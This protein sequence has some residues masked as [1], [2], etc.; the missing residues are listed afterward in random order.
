MLALGLL[1]AVGGPAWAAPTAQCGGQVELWFLNDESTSVVSGTSGTPNNEFED[2]QTFISSVANSFAFDATAGFRGALVAWATSPTLISG[3]TGSF[4]TVAAAYTRNGNG[5]TYPGA[6]MSYAANGIT[7]YDTSA[8]KTDGGAPVRSSVPSIVVM[9]T[10]AN[11]LTSGLGKVS[12]Q[13]ALEAGAKTLRDA[14]H[15]IV[16][17]LAAEA[18]LRY[19]PANT[20]D[21]RN[22]DT[23]YDAAFKTMMD[24]VA[25]AAS[26]VIV[27]STYADIANPTK[28]YIAALSDRICAVAK[29]IASAAETPAMTVTKTANAT[30]LSN[31][32]QPGDVLDYTITVK[33]SGNVS[34]TNVVL[35]DA[36]TADEVYVSGDTNSN[37]VLDVGETW[38]YG[39]SYTLTQADL[40]A[41][42]V[43]NV[44]SATATP[45]SG[46]ADRFS[47][48]SGAD[49]TASTATS[50]P[51]TGNGVVTPLTAKAEL[52][53]TKT[54]DETA[55]D[56]GVRVGDVLI[57]T[58]LVKNTGNVTLSD[59]GL[60]DDF[61]DVNGKPLTLSTG[62]VRI[63]PASG[64]T[65]APGDS[66]TYRATYALEA[67]AIA[68]GGVKNLATITASPPVGDPI[69]AQSAVGGNSSAAGNGSPTGTG[70]PGEVSGQVRAYLSGKAGVTVCLL[71]ATGADYVPVLD[72][73]NQPV[74]TTTDSDGRYR[75]VGLPAGT[76]GL[77]FT[78]PGAAIDPTAASADATNA[79]NRIEAILVGAGAVKVNQDAVFVDPSGVVYD[80]ESFAPLPGVKVTLTF[81]GTAVPDSWLDVTL[82][83]ANGSLTD[84]DGRYTYI[85]NAATAQSGTYTLVVEK[86]GYQVS[87]AVPPQAGPY[88]PGLGG[89]LE[90]IVPDDTPNAA[91]SQT[92]YLGFALTFD[93]EAASA[94]SNGVVNNHIPLDG[95]LLPQIKDE[96]TH[97][98]SND[99]AATMTQQA[100]RMQSYASGA[101][102]RLKSRHTGDYCMAAATAL[103]AGSPLQF[104]SASAVIPAE[105]GP[106][107]DRLA[108]L[109]SGCPD[110]RFEIAGHT[111]SDGTAEANLALSRARAAAVAEALAQRGIAPAR[112][113]PRGYGETRP[114]ADNA[115]ADGKSRNRRVV[116]EALATETPADPCALPNPGAGETHAFAAHADDTGASVAGSFR[117][118][119]HDC[120]RDSWTIVSGDLSWTKPANGLSQ[121]MVGF[122][123]RRERFATPDR[124]SGT[125]FGLYGTRSAVT[126]L[127]MGQIDGVG[128]NA[129]LYGAARVDH[130]L[131][132]D[133]YLGIAG[134]KHRIDLTFDR[135]GGTIGATG[136]YTYAA[137][138]GGVAV[139]GET[140]ALGLTFSPRVGADLAWSPG[141]KAA[142]VAARGALR[143]TGALDLP[144][145]SGARLFAELRMS[146]LLPG[147]ADTLSVAPRLAYSRAIG[148]DAASFG[149]GTSIEY[150][151]P[152]DAHGR[153]WSLALDA[154][155]S[156]TAT[157]GSVSWRYVTEM[158]PGQFDSS[159]GMGGTGAVTVG[160]TY[161][162]SF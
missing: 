131:F 68:A 90:K 55:L 159:V 134:G 34:L 112:M 62:P 150:A 133:W 93:G 13:A 79:G 8:Y 132:V 17:M 82:G 6:A 120:Q 76:Y 61:T 38:S 81:N 147:D 108:A 14:G 100:G 118:E 4:P 60:Q 161:S 57:Y 41:G 35:D 125:F 40:D 80:S 98:L 97:I 58:I 20:Y 24:T 149:F 43:E 42:G 27:G 23:T 56:D 157:S 37:G 160:G 15:Q 94:T 148:A 69:S 103:L 111:D 116:F 156:G 154:E 44:A 126:G 22:P 104:A 122:S 144:A 26:N 18:A 141:G 48:Y 146:D 128:L 115:T 117:H 158:G 10:D 59:I 124:V 52:S 32:P 138:F 16:I 85:L 83:Q 28:G 77:Q 151:H 29:Q 7:A 99:M 127:A 70:F 101:L 114:I 63:A 50:A 65:M 130:A 96:L 30:G 49:A 152:L 71:Q 45:P 89:G 136:S 162:M 3:L 87:A 11:G 123:A 53:V 51:A 36:L 140:R 78:D 33:N 86:A 73:E 105:N 72:T 39:A 121:G 12:D 75:F 54:V 102:D 113:E 1:N 143:D 5:S 9:L 21:P 129:G 139:S 74:C 84:A 109:V 31:P 107:L 106:V 110:V 142:I 66:W 153:S 135:D 88:T 145:L 95:R 92:Y 2:S 19:D 137:G 46:A 64:T 155:Q 25:G 91:M 47:V 67:G 119:T